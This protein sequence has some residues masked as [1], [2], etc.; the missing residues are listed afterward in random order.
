MLMSPQTLDLRDAL[1]RRLRAPVFEVAPRERS[2]LQISLVDDA[3]DH[4]HRMI[5]LA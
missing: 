1:L 3:L 5:R 4:G 2:I